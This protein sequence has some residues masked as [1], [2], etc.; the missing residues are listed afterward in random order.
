MRVPETV[1]PGLLVAALS[2]PL[3]GQVAVGPELA[4]EPVHRTDQIRPTVVIAQDGTGLV[5]YY[6]NTEQLKNLRRL[7][8]SGQPY[9]DVQFPGLPI[10]E[11]V[12]AAESMVLARRGTG[13]ACM[14]DAHNVS[15]RPLDSSVGLA[16]PPFLVDPERDNELTPQ[17][18]L[19]R[20]GSLAV[21]WSWHGYDANEE[22]VVSIF[23]RAVDALG[24]A[25]GPTIEVDQFPEYLGVGKSVATLDSQRA[26]VVWNGFGL[27]GDANGIRG[28]IVERDGSFAGDEFGVN[29][30]TLG[31][32]Q[33]PRVAADE[34]GNFVVVWESVEQ[35]GSAT[36]VYAQRF[37]SNGQ[38]VGPEFQVSSDA[39]S[40]QTWPGVAMDAAG[41]F[42]VSYFSGFEGPGTDID[43]YIRA[44]RPDGTP[45]GPQMRV[46]EQVY[47][48]QQ[49]P[50]VALSD[51]G[52]IQVAYESWRNPPGDPWPYWDYDVMTRRFVL[53]CVASEKTLCLADGRFQ[54]RAFWRD[55]AGGEGLARAVSLTEDSGGLWFFL[56]DN[57]ELLVKMVDGCGYNQRFWIFAAGLTDLEVDL[58]VTDTWTGA[59]EVFQNPLGFPYAPVQEIGLFDT[60]GATPPS[61]PGGLP[62][63]AR[64]V[65]VPPPAAAA[66]GACTQGP[67]QHCLNGGRFRATAHW[68]DFAGGEGEAM[69][70]PF[71]DDSGLF[72][73][74]GPENLE[75]AV[76]VI[77]ACTEFDRFWVYAA[78]LTNVAVTLTVED[79]ETRVTWQQET[80]LGEPF[81]AILD[82]Q[83]FDTCSDP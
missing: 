69:T 51:S 44:Y 10:G 53:P 83:A 30:Y 7:D 76:K 24:V 54:V 75:L 1:L 36:G 4:V 60:C 21:A 68:R 33:Y 45:Y 3:A 55:Y 80:A 27:D 13:A 39:F 64:A 63:A 16:G 73:F 15:C 12:T 82:S 11:G 6:D 25:L 67:T 49:Y 20:D 29:T 52:L 32:Q 38:K 14:S 79:T 58:L 43:V 26:V 18:D 71:G 5:G 22:M 47:A 57:F 59:V 2:A 78:G 37:D 48:E 46:N 8:R 62:L 34:D 72:W 77:D 42:V 50:S 17:A 40:D 74:F 31:E 9:G 65:P 28:R 41:N 19:F 35:D 56:P 23:V 66:D 61:E 70:M 81:P